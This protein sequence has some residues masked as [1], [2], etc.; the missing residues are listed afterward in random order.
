MAVPL[1]GQ[2][3]Q[4]YTA[5]MHGTYLVPLYFAVIT[6]GYLNNKTKVLPGSIWSHDC[7]ITEVL[8]VRTRRLFLPE[9]F[10]Y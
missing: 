2:F 1:R 5:Y 8:N 7:L 4:L 10:R 6:F 3:T 9:Y